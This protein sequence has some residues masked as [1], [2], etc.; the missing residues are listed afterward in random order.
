MKSMTGFGAARV[1]SKDVDIEISIKSYNGRYL[2]IRVNLPREYDPFELDIKKKISQSVG[3]GNV[4]VYVNRKL[5]SSSSLMKVT[6]NKDLGGKWLK[7]Y[8]DLGKSLKLESLPTLDLISR[9]P[10]VVKLDQD[11]KVPLKEKDLMIGAI[12]QA[13]QK[14]ETERKREGE[15]LLKE[16]KVHVTALNRVVVQIEKVAKSSSK[17]LKSKMKKRLEP[18]LQATEIDPQRLISEVA[19]QVD[20]MDI[21]EEVAR[22]KEHIRHYQKEMERQGPIGKKLDFYTQELLREVNTIGS[23]SL[24]AKMNHLAV[25]AK[26]IIE[27]LREQV[28]NIE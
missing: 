23:K 4:S 19:L 28:Q 11:A 8:K 10:E 25:E 6:L 18:I 5:S 26:S 7:A 17:E 16:L 3:R 9:L 27:K 2:D 20:R 24:L 15:S 21:T 22:L 12:V 14:L 1:S 13:V